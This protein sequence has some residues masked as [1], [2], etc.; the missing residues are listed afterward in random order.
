MQF[1]KIYV[2]PKSLL[3][4]LV[5]RLFIKFLLKVFPKSFFSYKNKIKSIMNKIGFYSYFFSKVIFL[6]F[7]YPLYF[8]L[9]SRQI[10]AFYIINKFL[11]ILE[12]Q[13]IDFFLLKGCLLGAVRQESFAGR[14]SD[15]DLG[16]KED[17]LQK[18]LDAIPLL[19][20]NGAI[21]IRSQPYDKVENVQILLPCMLI[22]IAIF[23]KKKMDKDGM[24]PAETKECYTEKFYGYA[25]PVQD[26][27]N[28]IPIKPYGKEFMAPANP[29]MYLKSIYGI[30]WNKPDKK[31]F[32]WKK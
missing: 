6:R 12:K 18:L 1:K 8:R 20:K 26:L 4:G 7:R 21:F 24:E 2:K 15:I 25:F 14:P 10:Y 17:E 31:Q 29:E 19:K 3:R 11:K 13:K 22:D 28:L 32:F 9:P 5:Q 23:R 30:N 16:I 27:E